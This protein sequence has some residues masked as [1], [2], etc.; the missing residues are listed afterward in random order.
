MTTNLLKYVGIDITLV[1]PPL[2]EGNGS[3]DELPGTEKWC[4]I[5]PGQ[6]SR[7]TS[8]GWVDMRQT[9]DQRNAL[10]DHENFWPNLG[11]WHLGLKMSE[12]D[13]EFPEGRHWDSPKSVL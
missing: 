11:R 5:V 4:S 13:I 2:P 12:A 7:K 9:D 1:Q 3:Q 6:H 10:G 8:V